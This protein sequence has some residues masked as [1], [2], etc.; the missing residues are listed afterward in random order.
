[1]RVENL[2]FAKFATYMVLAVG[3]RFPDRDGSRHREGDRPSCGLREV[4]VLLGNGFGAGT[5][6]RPR[7]HRLTATRLPSPANVHAATVEP[8]PPPR[9]TRSNSSGCVILTR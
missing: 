8:V 7:T 4:K 5:A 9:I 2:N 3:R 1:M 6:C